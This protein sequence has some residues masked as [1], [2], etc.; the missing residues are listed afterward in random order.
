MNEDY[1]AYESPDPVAPDQPTSDDRTW[2]ALCHVGALSWY[3]GVPGLLTVFLLWILKKEQSSFI[4]HHGKESINFQISML[5]WVA[6]G[7][8]TFC[9]GVG[10]VILVLD[11][12]FNLI[13]VIIAAI[14]ASNGEHF[15]YP[16]TLRIIR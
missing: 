4:D 7:I 8:I 1:P 6:V 3:I 2:A 16:L 15:R 5:L 10:F 9:V 13:M 12:I 14:K 11:G